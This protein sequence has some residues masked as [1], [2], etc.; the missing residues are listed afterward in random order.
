M[1]MTHCDTP[2]ERDAGS[3]PVVAK[4][5]LE[6]IIQAPTVKCLKWILWTHFVQFMV[7]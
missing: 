6:N 3:L 7:K 2:H 4:I 1:M 5:I